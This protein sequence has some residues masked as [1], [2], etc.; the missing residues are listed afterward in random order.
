MREAIGK[1]TGAE[2][3]GGGNGDNLIALLSFPFAVIAGQVNALATAFD[4]VSRAVTGI[5]EGMDLFFDIF[6]VEDGKL[7]ISLQNLPTAIFG[8]M[9]AIL[10]AFLIPFMFLAGF[11]YGWVEGVI[12]FFQHLWDRLVGNS[13]IPEMMQDI[14]DEITTKLGEVAT[15]IGE[16]WVVQTL[17]SFLGWAL[18]IVGPGGVVPT[19]MQDIWNS[20]STKM[21]EVETEWGTR[22]GN[23][24]TAVDDSWNSGEGIIATIGVAVDAVAAFFGIDSTLGTTITTFINSIIV[25]A[26][27]EILELAAALD[28]LIKAWEAAKLAFGGGK[29]SG[30]PI[31]FYST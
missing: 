20:V 27:A 4:A 24:K 16:T 25:W 12:G 23:V 13:I 21:G 18:L 15:W 7:I 22:W 9:Q 28:A 6:S 1:L 10:T 8:A 19:A 5:V 14:Y 31:R 29:Q 26:A 11:I 17:A 30:G 3:A 2:G